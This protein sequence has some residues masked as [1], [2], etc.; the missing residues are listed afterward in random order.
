MVVSKVDY[1]IHCF[2]LFLFVH[3]RY[4]E[5]VETV[6]TEFQKR[7]DNLNNRNVFAIK[8]SEREKQIFDSR[9]V[10]LTQEAGFD[11]VLKVLGEAESAF[12]TE[13]EVVDEE[14]EDSEE[15]MDVVVVTEP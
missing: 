10:H 14:L 4:S 13:M 9:K 6:S 5:A 2:V 7:I 3:S 8:G 12:E 1:I 11:Y 15:R